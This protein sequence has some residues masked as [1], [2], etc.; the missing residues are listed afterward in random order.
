MGCGKGGTNGLLPLLMFS[1]GSLCQV[2]CDN[3]A[4]AAPALTSLKV[5]GH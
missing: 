1:A 3:L 2:V 5:T 4:V